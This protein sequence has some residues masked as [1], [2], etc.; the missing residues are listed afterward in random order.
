M[1][2]KINQCFLHCVPQN[3]EF[4]RNHSKVTQNLSAFLQAIQ[5][6]YNVSSCLLLYFVIFHLEEIFHGGFHIKKILLLFGVSWFQK[7]LRNDVLYY[8]E[9]LTNGLLLITLIVQHTFPWFVDLIFFFL[10]IFKYE[11]NSITYTL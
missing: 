7:S 3:P 8:T 11:N 9:P 5:E 1:Y 4:R 6:S 2:I 10:N